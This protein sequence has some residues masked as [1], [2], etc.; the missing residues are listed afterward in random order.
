MEKPGVI[1]RPVIKAVS[2][3]SL[4]V[5]FILTASIYSQ[6]SG[7]CP[8]QPGNVWAYDN[9]S[10]FNIVTTL[11]STITFDDSL[12]YNIVYS[13]HLNQFWYYYMRLRDDNYY[14]QR[15]PD[16]Y[17][18]PNHEYILYKKGAQLGDSWIQPD[19]GGITDSLVTEVSDTGL[20]YIF[21]QWVTY[22]VLHT[23]YIV[24]EYWQ[25]F[26]DEFGLLVSED[27]FGPAYYLY[28]CLL[29]G[30]AYGDTSVLSAEV[31]SFIA[32]V[33]NQ[34][35]LLTWITATETNNRGFEIQRKNLS[36]DKFKW[37]NIGFVAGNGTTTEMNSYH[38]TDE[39]IQPG[40]YSYRLKQL[41][42]GGSF[43]YSK[44]IEV[45]VNTLL[46]YSLE[47]N[48]PNPF[49]PT[50]TINYQIPETGFVTLKI[51]DTLGNEVAT[52]VNE[53]KNQGRYMI[54]FDAS[55]LASGAYIYQIRVNDYISSKKMLLLK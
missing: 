32:D 7:V 49:N 1:I 26:T 28:S 22:R 43:K 53:Q 41:D 14:V 31:T 33:S 24:I 48:F 36:E 44:E 2:F 15:M 9:F 38:F 18:A 35:V 50:T 45:N 55:K 10:S 5:F 4:L 40:K 21:N 47:Q 19:D 11:D 46:D 17:P 3:K 27:D 37:E 25:T 13:V 23:Y 8:L 52:L 42:F 12:T 29:N 54:D 34:N 39:N 20:A 6:P 51:Y 16:N 30:V